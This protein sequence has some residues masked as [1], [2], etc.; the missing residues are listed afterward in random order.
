MARERGIEI[1]VGVMVVAAILLL[2]GFIVLLGNISFAKGYRFFVD[3]NF[4]GNIQN[5]APVKLSGIKVGKVE[6]VQFLGGKLDAQ[7]GRRVQVRLK[8]WVED[9]VREAIRKDADFFV[10]TQGVLGEQYLEI[11]PGSFD[12]PPLP[13]N[14]IVKGT[15]PPRTDLIVARLYEF[16]DSITTLL[17]DDKELI[18]DFLKSGTSVV[19]TVDKLLTDNRAQIATLLADL[20]KF[21]E[22]TTALIKTVRVGVG[23]PEDVQRFIANLRQI[24]T[25]VSRDVDEIIGKTKKALDGVNAATAMLQGEDKKKITRALDEL[26]TLS[27]KASTIATDAQVIVANLRAGKGTAG[28]MLRD[29]Q[30]YEDVK[31]MVR[32]LKRNPWKFFWKE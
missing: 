7:T 20:D 23:K 24:S 13:E 22:E 26:S 32:D 16:L 25:S 28:A 1:K 2:G 19:R 3:F 18:V 31:E 6:E 11:V 27:A 30:I 8:V 14:A 9:R 12:K 29:E 17:R 4:S 21:T 15:D 10:N 5:G